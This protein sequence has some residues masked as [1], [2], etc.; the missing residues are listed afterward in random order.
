M[1]KILVTGGAGFI[2]SHFLKS[3]CEN[4]TNQIFCIDNLFTGSK[5]NIENLLAEENFEFI[6]HDVRK[7]ISLDVDKIYNF[8]CPASPIHYQRDPIYTLTT[9]VIGTLNLLE[10]AVKN[11]AQFFHA[12]TSEIYGDPEIHPQH[13]DYLGNVNP[14]GIRA[15]YDEGKRAAET[16]IYDFKRTKNLTVKV[17]RIFNTYGPNMSFDDGRVVSNFIVNAILNRDLEIYGDGQKTRSFCYIDDLISGINILSNCETDL[18][19][20]L[21]IGNNKEYTIL[22]LANMII[23]LTKSKSKIIFKDPLSDDP[24]KR[25]PDLTLINGFGW[26]PE[27]KLEVGLRK[28]IEYFSKLNLK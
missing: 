28:T 1:A 20:P 2:G 21:N 16:L 14:I 17:A 15:C 22:E 18:E 6:T 8:A 23:D 26:K 24:V 4:K 11:Q 27:V 9:S 19:K 12:S 25:Q 3:L 7:P 5:Q 10:L 13:E